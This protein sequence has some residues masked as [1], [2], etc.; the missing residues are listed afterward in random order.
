ML[1]IYR[2]IRC[3][4]VLEKGKAIR[5]TK[6]LYGVT[7]YQQYTPVDN[8]DFCTDCF[9]RIEKTFKKWRKENE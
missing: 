2:C 5:L 9:K 6:K 1:K 7:R 4:K 8:Y 3:G